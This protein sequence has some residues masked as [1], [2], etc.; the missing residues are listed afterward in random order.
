[1]DLNPSFTTIK[2]AIFQFSLFRSPRRCKCRAGAANFCFLLR[3]RQILSALP[4]MRMKRAQDSA[5]Q[6]AIVAPQAAWARDGAFAR[7]K[8]LICAS[9]L[10]AAGSRKPARISGGIL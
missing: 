2:T 10:W 6:G 3:E 8:G 1:M 4:V 7:Q 9:R 5:V